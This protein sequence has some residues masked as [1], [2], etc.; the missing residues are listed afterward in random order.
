MESRRMWVLSLAVVFFV[1]GLVGVALPGE[2]DY[3]THPIEM[4]ISAPPGG[5][6]DTAVRILQPVLQEALGQPL[7]LVSKTGAAGVQGTDYVAKAKPDGYKITVM[8]TIY[9][10]GAPQ[11][12]PAIPYKYTDFIPVCGIALDPVVVVS[13][14]DAPWKT[15]EEL[16]DYA[17]KNPGKLNYATP[18]L[19]T[20]GFITMELI[21]LSYGLDIVPV[22]FAGTGPVKTEVLGGHVNMGVGGFSGLSPLIKSGDFRGLVVTSPKRVPDFPAIPT[23]AEKGFPDASMSIWQT[24]FVPQDTPKAVIDKLTWAMDRA[25]KDPPTLN[26]FKDAALI[27]EHR[28]GE[29]MKKFIETEFNSVGKVVKKVGATK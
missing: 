24:L 21:K 6:Q 18:G 2:K 17:K 5:P 8:P 11:F 27:V 9:I 3:P 16:V 20:V 12:N 4:V 29:S 19:G 22:H 14:P 1:A 25:M 15:L 13:K 28:D 23:I 26:R 10:T 7:V